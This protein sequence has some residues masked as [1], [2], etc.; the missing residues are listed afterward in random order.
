MERV[1][2]RSI[3]QRCEAFIGEVKITRR[4]N[5]VIDVMGLELI[6]TEILAALDEINSVK[7]KGY[8]GISAELLKTFKEKGKKCLVE[9][10]ET[11][12]VQKILQKRW[13]TLKKFE[14][15]RF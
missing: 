7:T 1:Y 4:K 3:R 15:W 12:N 9:L 13:L 11:E 5:V 8:D 10:C 14:I 6:E 2:C